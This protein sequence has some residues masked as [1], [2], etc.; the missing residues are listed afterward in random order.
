[1]NKLNIEVHEDYGLLLREG[2]P[3]VK[4]SLEAANLLSNWE[5]NKRIP[6]D[7]KDA[8]SNFVNDILDNRIDLDP[9]FVDIVSE[10][11]W[12]LI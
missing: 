5:S 2:E 11:F 12:D 7:K 1:M 8:V 10:N 6:E 9:E 4:I 3:D